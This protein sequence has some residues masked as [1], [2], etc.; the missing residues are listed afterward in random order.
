MFHLCVQKYTIIRNYRKNCRN[1]I[2]EEESP[3]IFCACYLF[4]RFLQPGRPL[5]VELKL[6]LHSGEPGLTLLESVLMTNMLLELP[7][8]TLV[9][10]LKQVR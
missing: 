7:I 1:I 8:K 6:L 9:D 10:L 4:Q 5:I 2:T 3:R